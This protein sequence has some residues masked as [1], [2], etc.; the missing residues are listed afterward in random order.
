M[1]LVCG[2]RWAKLNKDSSEADNLSIDRQKWNALETTLDFAEQLPE[3]CPPADASDVELEEVYRLVRSK[4]VDIEVFKSHAALGKV[5]PKGMDLC[6]WSSC[7]LLLDGKRSK[8]PALKD[9]DWAAR[10][11]VPK[12][13]GM[14]KQKKNHVDFWCGKHF[15]LEGA[16]VEVVR[17]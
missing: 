6:R 14:S 15:S 12:G 3:Q 17:L 9:C 5:P 10:L 2:R 7:S 16:V 4:N 8:L 11:V 1:L 13:A